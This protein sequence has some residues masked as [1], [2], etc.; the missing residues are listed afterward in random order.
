MSSLFKLKKEDRL[1]DFF[2][3]VSRVRVIRR[4][5]FGEES[6]RVA[7]MKN[8]HVLLSRN[9]YLKAAC[10]LLAAGKVEECLNVILKACQRVV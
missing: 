6:N 2:Q 8:A 9:E 7:A 4:R 5:D 1:A 3:C 10:F